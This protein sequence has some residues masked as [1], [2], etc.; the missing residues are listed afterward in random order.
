MCIIADSTSIVCLQG[1]GTNSVVRFCYQNGQ[2]VLLIAR[3][4]RERRFVQVVIPSPPFMLVCFNH[5]PL[6]S[7]SGTCPPSHADL[8]F[9]EI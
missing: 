9:V 4:K 7:L 6:S 2:I 8:S 5:S 1:Q 3:K